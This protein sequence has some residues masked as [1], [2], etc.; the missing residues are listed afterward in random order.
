MEEP[1]A[2]MRLGR[3]AV[4]GFRF[5]SFIFRDPQDSRHSSYAA[6]FLGNVSKNV[7][8]SLC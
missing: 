4:G 1:D 3:A 7:D 2:K 6:E 8:A 5:T